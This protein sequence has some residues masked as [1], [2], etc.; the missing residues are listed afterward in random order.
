VPGSER[1]IVGVI[2]SKTSKT[3]C[4]E[5][6]SLRKQDQSKKLTTIQNELA[7]S[8]GYKSYKDLL[9][10]EK[11]QEKDKRIQFA[12]SGSQHAGDHFAYANDKVEVF[13]RNDGLRGLRALVNFSK[14][15]VILYESA[16]LW[17]S[18]SNDVHNEGL[19]W[20][21]TRNIVMKLPEAVHQME[22]VGKFRES[23][24]SK[25]DKLDKKVLTAI[26]NS[27]GQPEGYV[28]KVYNLV[29]TYNVITLMEI[30]DP[31]SH[32]V[33]IAHRMTISKGLS[34]ANHSCEPN[35]ERIKVDSIE[36]FKS[37]KD[38]LV[39]EKEISIGDEIT[40]SY[41]DEYKSKPLKDRQKELKREY[42]FF[43]TCSLCNREKYK[44]RK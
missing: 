2:M 11:K 43:C 7:I 25:L 39:A 37:M 17:V 40:W 44:P 35:S 28:K 38:G 16:F 14:G 15:D 33:M 32:S 30:Y 10:Q 34:Y 24:C 1:I 42:G 3:I 29:C 6:K 36:M 4:R 23:F 31:N 13:I 41:F 12:K 18:L 20:A 26:S 22:K 5:A 8:H 9:N 19:A 27:C 21:L